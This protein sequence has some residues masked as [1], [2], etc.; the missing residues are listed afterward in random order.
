MLRK[1]ILDADH[2]AVPVADLLEWATWFEHADRQVA[3]TERGGV[4]VSTVFLGLDHRRGEDGPPILFE[5]MTFGEP[6]MM[7]LFGRERMFRRSV[8]RWR[9]ST[10]NEA[11]EGHAAA[12]AML[13]RVLN[14]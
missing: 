4:L 10:W 5:T 12:V 13:Q 8:N 6:E 7:R 2:N 11:L 3:Q 14:S 1:Y 9:Y